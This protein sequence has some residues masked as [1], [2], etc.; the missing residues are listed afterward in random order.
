M[1]TEK[2]Q[3]SMSPTEREKLDDLRNLVKDFDDQVKS[4]NVDFNGLSQRVDA[5]E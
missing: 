4:G 5:I 2:I 1:T 3:R